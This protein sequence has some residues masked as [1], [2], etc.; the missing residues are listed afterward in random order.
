MMEEGY[1]LRYNP[2][3]RWHGP[4]MDHPDK[5][6]WNHY[7]VHG[8]SFRALKKEGSIKLARGRTYWGLA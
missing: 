1:L 3:G 2:N 8:N 7:G 5:K 6:E 4:W